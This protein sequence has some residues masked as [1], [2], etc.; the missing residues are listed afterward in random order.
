L[1]YIKFWNPFTENFHDGFLVG[2]NETYFE[3]I[4]P[5]AYDWLQ[6][7]QSLEFIHKVKAVTYEK[8]LYKPFDA[9]YRSPLSAEDKWFFHFLKLEHHIEDLNTIANFFEWFI[10]LEKTEK[11]LMNAIE[12][13]VS[14]MKMTTR[15]ELLQELV[16]FVI[17]HK[18][19]KNEPERIRLLFLM[20]KGI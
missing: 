10:H 8:S 16:Q 17:A 6:H 7:V 1:K 19:I 12:Q 14:K 15:K 13:S 11:T 20:I 3:I 5:I 18:D 4:Y 9:I 2:E